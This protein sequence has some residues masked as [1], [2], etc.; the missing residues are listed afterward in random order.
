LNSRV[1]VIAASVEGAI[2]GLGWV[3]WVC[4]RKV[5]RSV[6]IELIATYK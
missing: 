2:L 6:E 3:G 1:G 5:T 4:V